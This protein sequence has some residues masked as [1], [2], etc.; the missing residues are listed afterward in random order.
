MVTNSISQPSDSHVCYPY[1][2]II[3]AIIFSY[4][5]F[6]T[7]IFER[8]I[9][10]FNFHARYT[11]SPDPRRKV[12]SKSGYEGWSH[13]NENSTRRGTVSRAR[14]CF[15]PFRIRGWGKINYTAGR[16]P[17]SIMIYT[18]SCGFFFPF[19]LSILMYNVNSITR[20]IVKFVSSIIYIIRVLVRILNFH[21]PVQE[22]KRVSDPK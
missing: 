9:V 4:F 3:L 12:T 22:I 19:Y 16:D 21:L 15:F 13:T 7:I 14:P 11:M 5:T 1:T 10:V 8:Y 20:V 17:S 2:S 18:R 6:S